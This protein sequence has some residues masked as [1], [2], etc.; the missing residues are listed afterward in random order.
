MANTGF[1]SDPST[2]S[3]VMFDGTTV[4]ARK[5]DN[6]G[7]TDLAARNLTLTGGLTVVTGKIN[8]AITT[9]GAGTL[10]GAALWGGTITRTGPVAAY[11][12]TTDT[13]ALIIAA[14]SNAVIGESWEVTIKNTVPFTATLA[15]GS[16]VTLS[17]QTIIPP[18][19][20]GRFLLTYNGAGTIT[21]VGLAMVPM[22][23]TMPEVFTALT[24]VGAGTILAASIAGGAVNRTGPTSAAVDTT[25]TAALIIAAVPNANVG[26]SWE[27]TYYNN[28]LGACT[29]TAGASVTVTGGIVPANTWVRFLATI[30]TATTVTLVAVAAGPCV[31]LPV[32]KDSTNATATLVAG[33]I[34]GAQIVNFIATG[35]NATVTTRTGAQMFGDIPGCQIGYAYMVLWRNTNATGNT[36]TAADG[37]VTLTGTMTVAQNVTRIL[38]VKFTSVTAVTITSMGVLAAAA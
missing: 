11:T 23:T 38:S 14:I 13:A 35:A 31:V 6:S 15:G 19:S 29:V 4:R 36:I 2:I 12:D 24:T 18:N 21:M 8:T 17:G 33:D 9:V 16:G 25:D 7:D 26:Q 22:T 20:V 10:T 30:N 1:F 32:S 5:G 3:G 34:S 28:S 37:T 27:F